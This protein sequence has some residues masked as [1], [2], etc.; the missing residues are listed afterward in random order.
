MSSNTIDKNDRLF[1]GALACVA[2][3]S[4]WLLAR[5][6]DLRVYWYA[7]NGYFSGTRPAY[8]LTSGIGFPMEYRYPPVT[9]LLLWPLSKLSLRAAGFWWMLGA[10]ATAVTSVALGARMRRLE[11]NSQAVLLASGFL[12]AYVV[13]AIRYG[14]VQPFVIAWLY[15]ALALAEAYPLAAGVLFSLAVTFKI[16]PILFL[17]WFLRRT[18]WRAAAAFAGSLAALWIVP[19]LF[20]GTAEYWRLLRD[21]YAAV[22][23]V[24]TTYSELYYFPGQSIRGIFLRY[25]SPVAP[26]LAGFPDIHFVSLEPRM[27]ATLWM[28]IGFVI[29]VVCVIAMLRSELRKMWIW[30]GL[31]FVLYSL[32]EPYAV[33]SGLIS[34]APAVLT[35]AALFTASEQVA[36]SGSSARGIRLTNGLFVAASLMAFA[37]AI[38]QH[39]PWQRWLLTV[40]LDFWA[41]ILLAAALLFWIK[42]MGPSAPPTSLPD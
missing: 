31:V 8:G 19:L 37:G 25:L 40:G 32:L 21:W 39:R 17:P 10:W 3:L 12:L 18:R 11:F 20:F 13:L 9:Y 42:N 33:K 27:A 23:R 26:P 1:Y 5:N 36:R 6:T 29:Y 24:G 16:W 34:V 38:I 4:A 41:E 22:G 15:A 2:V 7:V 14:N 30:D 28:V 35:A